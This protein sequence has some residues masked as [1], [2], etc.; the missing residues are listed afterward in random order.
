MHLGAYLTKTCGARS[1]KL[2][3]RECHSELPAGPVADAL[4]SRSTCSHKKSWLTTHKAASE[5]PT[6]ADTR[7]GNHATLLQQRNTTHTARVGLCGYVPPQP[8]PPM[9]PWN[10]RYGGPFTS[11]HVPRSPG[12]CGIPPV[13][14]QVCVHVKP[15]MIGRFPP[16]VPPRS[17]RGTSWP[18]CPR[19]V[20]PPGFSRYGCPRG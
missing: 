2:P 16:A 5:K 9:G 20:G 1:L 11:P 4:L 8:P 15:S 10:M 6:P 18:G 13:F 17:G 14:L 7:I 19:A 12:L 3:A